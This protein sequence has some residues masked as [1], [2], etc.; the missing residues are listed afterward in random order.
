MNKVFLKGN[1]TRDPELRS[2]SEKTDVVNFG[3]AVNRR[4]NKANGDKGEETN[5]FDCE[6]WDSGARTIYQYLAKGDPILIEGELKNDNW[7]KDGQKFSRTKVRVSSFEFVGKRNKVEDS[8]EDTAV[9]S[10]VPGSE[11]LGEEIPF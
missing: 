8:A 2:V 6:A 1:L 10:D 7:E 4:F 3:I 9:V 5:F 11:S